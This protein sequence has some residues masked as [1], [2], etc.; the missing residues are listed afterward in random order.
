MYENDRKDFEW[1]WKT[2][3]SYINTHVDTILRTKFIKAKKCNGVKQLLL[4][5]KDIMNDEIQG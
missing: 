4:R 5:L 3:E 2:Y 1:L